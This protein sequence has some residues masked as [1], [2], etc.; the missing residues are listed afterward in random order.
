LADINFCECS[1]KYICLFVYL[2]GGRAYSTSWSR[3]MGRRK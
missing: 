1:I 2:L 3:K